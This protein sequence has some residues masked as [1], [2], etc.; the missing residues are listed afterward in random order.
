VVLENQGDMSGGMIFTCSRG[1][2]DS[3]VEALLDAGK[4]F[5][6]KPAGEARFTDWLQAISDKQ[7]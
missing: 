2:A 5:N 1:Y 3:M 4:E 7:K 6:L